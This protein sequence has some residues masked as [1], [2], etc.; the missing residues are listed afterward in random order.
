MQ[1]ANS[2]QTRMERAIRT[3][4]ILHDQIEF[5]LG[6]HGVKQVDNEG[7][8]RTARNDTVDYHG[9]ECMLDAKDNVNKPSPTLTA[10]KMFRSDLV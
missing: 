8:L 5:A 1:S 6:L 4:K 7:K 9:V 3:S 2:N 10:C